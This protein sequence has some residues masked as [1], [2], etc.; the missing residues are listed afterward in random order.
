MAKP[1][2]THREKI[3]TAIAAA[4]NGPGRHADGAGLYLE[5]DPPRHPGERAGARRW[6]LRTVVHG[7]RRDIGLGSASIVTLAE[8]REEAAK[9][10]KT[11]RA[12]GDPLAER[13][14]KAAP[15]FETAARQCYDDRV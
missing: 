7:R 5:V 6:L 2:G 4:K 11:A 10:R 3:L 1:T 14:K 15:T 8:A 13:R 9:F 12:G